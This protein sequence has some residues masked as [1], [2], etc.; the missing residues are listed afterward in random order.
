[1][2]DRHTILLFSYLFFYVIFDW[3]AKAAFVIYVV[4]TEQLFVSGADTVP[5]F[6]LMHLNQIAKAPSMIDL[7]AA[8]HPVGAKPVQREVKT[9]VARQML[10]LT[11][12]IVPEGEIQGS[13]W[14]IQDEFIGRAM[15]LECT[16]KLWELGSIKLEIKLHAL[17][18]CTVYM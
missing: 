7:Q 1:M 16:G 2:L 15:E 13:H 6:S 9:D 4:L 14:L 3:V 17:H 11:K 18:V 8:W 10:R 5:F 12:Q